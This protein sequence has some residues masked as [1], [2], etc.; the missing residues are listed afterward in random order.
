MLFCVHGK[1]R[2]ALQTMTWKQTSAD[3]ELLLWVCLHSANQPAA[4]A[5]GEQPTCIWKPAGWVQGSSQWLRDTVLLIEEYPGMW[6]HKRG[7][8]MANKIQP[9]CFKVSC[10]FSSNGALTIHSF[11]HSFKNT[12]VSIPHP[13]PTNPLKI[14]Q[15]RFF[16]MY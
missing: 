7:Q 9:F 15:K 8:R 12:C 1:I 5:S 6:T 3:L 2:F 16:L 4:W 14:T 13:T 11:I 10:I